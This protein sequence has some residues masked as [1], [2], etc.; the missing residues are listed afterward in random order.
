MGFS[1]S[2]EEREYWVSGS[3]VVDSEK[4]DTTNKRRK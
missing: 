1:G 2:K 3:T 4:D